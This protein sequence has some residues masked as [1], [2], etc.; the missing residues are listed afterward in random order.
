MRPG[1]SALPIALLRTEWKENPSSRKGELVRRGRGVF[2]THREAA[3]SAEGEG[4][5][6]EEADKEVSRGRT[7]HRRPSS[8]QA[9][10][11]QH[12]P[13]T[14]VDPDLNHLVSGV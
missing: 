10:L 7:V 2:R 3:I 12:V 8:S 13:L 11:T 1:R 4:Q 5:A 6:G 14:G 9:Q